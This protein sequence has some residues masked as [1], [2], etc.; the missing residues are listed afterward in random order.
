VRGRA[1]IGPLTYRSIESLPRDNVSTQTSFSKGAFLP[2]LC[3][4]HASKALRRHQVGRRP[5]TLPSVDSTAEVLAFGE[6]VDTRGLGRPAV[7][8]LDNHR[9]VVLDVGEAEDKGNTAEVAAAAWTT[10]EVLDRRFHCHDY[11]TSCVLPRPATTTVPSPLVARVHS[12]R[13][14]LGDRRGAST[15]EEEAWQNC[16]E[17]WKA[18]A[19]P[20]HNSLQ[21]SE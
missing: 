5:T 1:Q 12:G 14:S 4:A 18:A 15:E 13:L 3:A 20:L 16:D 9:V 6:A 8:V 10:A 11:Q 17:H 19:A 21:P 7:V 2:S